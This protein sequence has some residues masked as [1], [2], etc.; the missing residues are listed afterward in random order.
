MTEPLFDKL[1]L[2][3]FKFQPS[4]PEP[5]GRAFSWTFRILAMTMLVMSYHRLPIER[6]AEA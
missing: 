6:K 4:T 2:S 3:T 5:S 1:G